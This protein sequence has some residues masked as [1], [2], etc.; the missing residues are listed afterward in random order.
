MAKSTRPDLSKIGAAASATPVQRPQEARTSRS[1]VSGAEV[2]EKK[3]QPS[4]ANLVA[5]TGHFPEE[6]RKQLKLISI[7]EDMRMQ[8]LLG[9]AL[10]HL[11]VAYGKP[12]I[13][14]TEKAQD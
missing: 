10:N 7:E 6:V 5:I 14:P 2:T 3:V 9:Q 11:F 1:R 12:E 13:A 8:D 4:R